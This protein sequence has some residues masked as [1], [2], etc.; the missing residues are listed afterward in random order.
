VIEISLLNILGVAILALFI[1]HWFEP[2]QGVKNKVLELLGRALPKVF[3]TY[4]RTLF[5]CSKCLSFWLGL[6]LFFNLPAAACTSFL[7][8]ILNH[9]IDRVDHWYE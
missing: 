6:F 1:A 3:Y 4:I 5:T 7:G 2:I 9:I 8:F